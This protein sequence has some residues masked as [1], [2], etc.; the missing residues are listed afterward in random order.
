[1]NISGNPIDF[2]TG[3]LN[4]EKRNYRKKSQY[5]TDVETGMENSSFR[6][7]ATNW[8]R[9]GPLAKLDERTLNFAMKVLA[10]AGDYRMAFSVI[11]GL[12]LEKRTPALYHA[13]ITACSKANPPKGRTAMLLW[14]KMK[15]QGFRDEISRATYNALLNCA[16]GAAPDD[17]DNHGDL[18]N[19]NATTAILREMKD[20]GIGLNVV[21]YNIALNSL[22]DGGRFG[23]M[24]D[25]LDR[26]ENSGVSP[27]PITFGTAIHGAARANNSN[28]AVALLRADIKHC[29][30]KP[31]DAAF[32]AAL[33][34]CVRDPDASQ[35][36]ASAQEVVAIMCDIVVDLDERER[37]EQLARSALHRGILD[38]D[39][40]DRAEHILGMA[41]HN[42]R[43]EV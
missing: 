9:R 20:R 11:D 39:K 22:A 7:N 19:A 21:S 8:K 1:M 3:A 26:M 27:T 30:E 23:E 33:E 36:A 15:T 2:G 5:E 12:P 14:K 41:L 43:L 38:D 42:R 16:Q 40:I 28:A 32:G 35:G 25:L 37:I 13:A 24:L 34:A 29:N 4:K 31:T 6:R 10:K 17:T 18:A